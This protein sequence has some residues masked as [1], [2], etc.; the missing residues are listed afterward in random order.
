M[1]AG[2]R[3]ANEK[4]MFRLMM[5]D[6]LHTPGHLLHPPATA[7][8]L[9]TIFQGTINGAWPD[10]QSM[11]EVCFRIECQA[12]SWQ[13]VMP[14]QP[15]SYQGSTPVATILQKLGQQMGFPRSSDR[16][17]ARSLFRAKVRVVQCAFKEHGP[18]PCEKV[19][20]HRVASLDLDFEIRQHCNNGFNRWAHAGFF[21][22]A[23]FSAILIAVSVLIHCT[24]PRCA[25]NLRN[26]TP[27]SAWLFATDTN[28]VA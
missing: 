14:S 24:G 12:G 25:Q 10:A 17:S 15:T 22:T 26:A 16:A 1:Q 4:A 18:A 8:S 27:P 3:T 7:T 9:T 23:V 11:P 20:C 21:G 2:L 28:T 13:A 6:P 5:I 19:C